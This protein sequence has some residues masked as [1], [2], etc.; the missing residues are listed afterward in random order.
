MWWW[1]SV[2]FAGALVLAIS[3]PVDHGTLTWACAGRAPATPAAAA[4]DIID[5]TSR[6]FQASVM[7]F[8]PR[9]F[10]TDTCYRRVAAKS[11]AGP[12]LPLPLAGEGRG[13]GR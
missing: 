10:P 7:C 5:N 4:A 2:A 3:V 11:A 12:L 9:M 8:L 13:G 1:Q 6:R